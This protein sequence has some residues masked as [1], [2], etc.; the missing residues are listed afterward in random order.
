MANIV[1]QSEVM[2]KKLLL[3]GTGYEILS[4]GLISYPF[5]IGVRNF[6]RVLDIIGQWT[7]EHKKLNKRHYYLMI[8]GVEPEFQHQ[9]IGSRLTQGGIEKADKEK[10]G[11]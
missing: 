8:I 5:R 3:F 7:K 2:K 4:M 1:C 9:G 6:I 10:L 11:L